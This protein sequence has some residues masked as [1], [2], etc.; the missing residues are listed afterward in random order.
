MRLR[1]SQFQER[2]REMERQCCTA[3]RISNIKNARMPFVVQ[4][5]SEMVETIS[6][7]H[8]C[9]FIFKEK[10]TEIVEKVEMERVM[11]QAL[12][13]IAATYFLSSHLH[14]IV[15]STEGKYYDN[16]IDQNKESGML[17][18]NPYRPIKLDGYNPY[19][20]IC[21]LI[22]EGFIKMW[23]RIPVFS[24]QNKVGGC[25]SC[26]LKAKWYEG[27]SCRGWQERPDKD[28]WIHNECFWVTNNEEREEY[29]F[30]NPRMMGMEFWH[31]LKWVPMNERI[32][33]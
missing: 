31:F 8:L 19:T 5:G 29:Q 33:K 17:F 11:L 13:D 14:V 16:S 28:K 15:Y 6:P 1:Y 10:Y 30:I 22:R 27:T 18:T 2:V 21:S 20:A 23:E 26:S 7:Y 3:R 4:L 25:S 9:N 24:E 32:N 12:S